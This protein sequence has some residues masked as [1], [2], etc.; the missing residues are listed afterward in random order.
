MMKKNLAI[1]NSQH[2]VLINSKMV[3]FM[4]DSGEMVKDMPKEFS[5]GLMGLFMKDIG[6]IVK[7][8]LFLIIQ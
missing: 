8:Y 3:Q 4:W 6:E 1:M 5:T 2:S 7:T